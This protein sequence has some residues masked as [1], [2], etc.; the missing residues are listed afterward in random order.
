[1]LG[2]ALQQWATVPAD[3]TSPSTAHALTVDIRQFPWIRRLASDYAFDYPRVA[4]FFA[5]NPAAD[6]AWAETIARSQATKRRP[7]ELARVIADQQDRR[8]AP[9]EARRSAERLVDPATRVVITG[10]QAGLF[11]GP[12]FTLL[13]AL[14]AMRLAAEVERTHGV[15]V[16]PVFWIDAEDHDWAEV[17]GCTVLDDDLAPRTIRLPDPGGRRTPRTSRFARGARSGGTP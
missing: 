12:L 1:M 17:S 2:N 8:E 9:A 4:T 6:T 10:Q 16:V 15:S 7:A 3:A 11:G 14:T 13:K 5:G